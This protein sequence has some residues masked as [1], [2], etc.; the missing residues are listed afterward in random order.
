M[1]TPSGSPRVFLQFI[2]YIL[3]NFEKCYIT[4][5]KCKRVIPELFKNLKYLYFT[6]NIKCMLL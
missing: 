4:N 2:Y 1:K 6:K 5:L 3:N